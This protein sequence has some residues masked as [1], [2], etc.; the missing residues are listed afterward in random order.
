MVTAS[1]LVLL[2]T[3]QPFEIV[4]WQSAVTEV[5]CEQT[6]RVISTYD[7]LFVHSTRNTIP[8]PAVI[9]RE[10]AMYKPRA[11]TNEVPFN[12]ENL[13]NRD[14]GKCMYCGKHV[15][16]DDFSFAHDIYFVNIFNGR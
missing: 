16:F 10:D 5:Y 6:A 13:F 14:E 15:A 1:S 3:F 9:L 4:S 7:N 2:P 11:F 8:V 12:R